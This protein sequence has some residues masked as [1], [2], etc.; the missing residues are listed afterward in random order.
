MVRK[1]FLSLLLVLVCT[2]TVLGDT[3][4]MND[5]TK[6]QG[7]VIDQGDKYWLKDANGDTHLVDKSTVSNWTRGDAASTPAAGGSTAAPAPS[8]SGSG[9][10]A[11]VKSKADACDT[12]IA[13][14]GLWQNFIDGKPSAADLT[15]AKAELKHWQE[16]VDGNGEKINGKWVWGEDREKLVAKVRKLMEEGTEAL[17]SNQTLQGIAKFEEAVKLYPNNFEANFELGYY[18]LLKGI[19]AGRNN[20]KIEDGIK[21]MEMAVKLRPDCAAAWSDLAI[22]YNFK[23]KYQ[24]SVET[25]YKAA[26]M[27]DSKPIVQNLMNSIAYAPPGMQNNSAVK[28]IIEEALILAQKY[29]MSTRGAEKWEWV[30]PDAEDGEGGGKVGRRGKAPGHGGDDEEK[31]GPPGIIGNGSGFFIS[32]N[33]YILTNRHVAK[34]GDYLMVRLS[35]NTLKLADRVVIDDEQDMAVIKIKTPAPV[36]YVKLAKYD[37]PAVG[38]EVS[39]FGF[40]IQG[41]FGMRSSVK[42]TRGIVT[43]IDSD[44]KLCDV[45]VDAAVNPGNSGGCMIDK[46]GNLLALTAMKTFSSEDEH[47]SSYGLGYSDLRV[48]K[49]F[50]KQ[51]DKLKDA[52][53]ED[54]KDDGPVLDS[55]ALAAKMSPITVCIFICRGTPPNGD[56]AVKA[57]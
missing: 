17:D 20:S 44:A 15:A 9:S 25:A 19:E 6:L 51:A 40:P 10:F 24:L 34:E 38:A 46:R 45:T 43:A 8:Y 21:S 4:T 30:R 49:F 50:K 3:L 48:R 31:G 36:D 14:V 22:G 28:P 29:G 12:P 1:I 42:M 41:V 5:G 11:S 54:A 16:L 7:R 2:L 56:G 33:G 23:H 39:V 57:K 53:L 32:S 26:K 27:E 55:E 13:A 52:H 37:H 35:D 47:I 18:N